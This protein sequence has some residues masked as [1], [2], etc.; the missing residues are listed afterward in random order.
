MAIMNDNK[1]TI[2]KAV[3][4]VLAELPH[5]SCTLGYKIHNQVIDKLII[6]GSDKRPLDSTTLRMVRYFG[7]LYGVKAKGT[8]SSEYIKQ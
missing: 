2:T 7:A 6:N 8:G 4:E 1:Y 3:N 5:G